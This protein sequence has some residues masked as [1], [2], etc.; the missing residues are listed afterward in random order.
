M[1]GLGQV[2]MGMPITFLS[3]PAIC[4]IPA[5]FHLLVLYQFLMPTLEITLE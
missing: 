3:Q 2:W 1:A 4:N 5:A